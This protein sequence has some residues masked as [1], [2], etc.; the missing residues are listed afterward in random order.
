MPRASTGRA[1]SWARANATARSGLIC[2]WGWSRRKAENCWRLRPVQVL[3]A[4]RAGAP[5]GD[6]GRAD[7]RHAAHALGSGA[8]LGVAEEAADVDHDLHRGHVEHD[9]A[10]ASVPE[11]AVEEMPVATE[12]RGLR[13]AMKQW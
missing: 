8:E 6:A 11:C 10:V 9:Q 7:V 4:L 2:W 5:A 3:L 12:E 1:G 13:Q